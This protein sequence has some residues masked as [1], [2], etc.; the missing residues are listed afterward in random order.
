M[1]GNQPG[2]CFFHGIVLNTNGCSHWRTDTSRDRL[3]TARIKKRQLGQSVSP[4]L[5]LCLALCPPQ[6]NQLCLT[7]ICTHLFWVPRCMFAQA[8]KFIMSHCACIENPLK[9]RM[10]GELVLSQGLIL[11]RNS[12]KLYEAS[13]SRQKR[14]YWLSPHQQINDATLIVIQCRHHG[15]VLQTPERDQKKVS[16]QPSSTVYFSSVGLWSAW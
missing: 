2:P 3:P 6:Y 12:G 11:K 1:K 5:L 13:S 16:W 7:I 10:R 14:K 9:N 4:Y 15:Y 8:H